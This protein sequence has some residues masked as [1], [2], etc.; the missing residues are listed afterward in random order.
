V[1]QAGLHDVQQRV[2]AP[3]FVAVFLL[4]GA[5]PQ[6]ALNPPRPPRQS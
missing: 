4:S 1:G 6:K 2:Q 5:Q 3:I